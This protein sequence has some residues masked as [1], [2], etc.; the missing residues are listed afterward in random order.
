MKLG[1]DTGFL[2]GAVEKTLKAQ[3]YWQGVLDGHHELVISV[4][5]VHEL[6]VHYLRRGKGELIR[7]F[8]T[9]L[10]MLDNVLFISVNEAIAEQAAGYRL[11]LGIPTV[12]ALIL[13][14]FVQ[15]GCELVLTT[16]ADFL[17]AAQQQIVGVELVW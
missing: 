3:P 8:L 16:D 14:T 17:L 15:S 10:R 13:A 11:G 5:T 1:G 4:L 9:C 12:D 7:D 2:M 6:L